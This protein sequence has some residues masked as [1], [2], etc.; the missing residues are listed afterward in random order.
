M[1]DGE[2]VCRYKVSVSGLLLQSPPCSLLAPTS[3]DSLGYPRLEGLQGTHFC[4]IELLRV[5]S[6]EG[7]VDEGVKVALLK[8]DTDG[9]R[10]RGEMSDSWES[11]DK[12]GRDREREERKRKRGRQRVRDKVRW[13]KTE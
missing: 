6:R 7:Q 2:H 8:L 11:Q 10:P 12:T 9:S 3:R 4:S 13:R 1:R 5:S